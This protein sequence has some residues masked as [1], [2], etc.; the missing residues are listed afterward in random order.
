MSMA[1]RLIG[2]WEEG[3][4]L[5]KHIIHSEYQ[6]EDEWGRPDFDNTRSEIG[7]FVYEL[8]YNQDKR[9]LNDL[10]DIAEIFIIDEWKIDKYID[11][12]VPIPPSKTNRA[13]QPVFEICNSLGN[14]LGKCVDLDILSKTET[15]QI[16][17]L[18]YREKEKILMDS[19]N[20]DYVYEERV[21]ILLIDDLYDSGLTIK[22]TTNLLQ[23]ND[24]NIKN[25]YVLTMT[26]TRG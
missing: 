25:I 26:K 22:T 2:P 23:K 18:S 3:Y 6:G 15:K 13:F 7:Q 14:R 12:I 17:N 10:I 19:I 16:K 9:V 20:V 4:A 24:K 21:N 1:I 11:A 5:D 8:K